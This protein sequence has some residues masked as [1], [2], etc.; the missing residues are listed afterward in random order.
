[1]TEIVMTST[2][3][4]ALRDDV[5]FLRNLVAGSDRWLVGF[6]EGYFAA[7]LIY[8]AQMLMH[9]GQLLGLAPGSGVWAL[10]IG[11]GPTLVFIPLVTWI[12]W[13]HR[14]QALPTPAGRAVT[15]VFAVAGLSNLALIAVIGSVAWREQSL[16]TWLIYPCAVFVFQGA[17]W[18]VAYCVRR[19]AWLAC[20][21]A[22]W[23][24][25]AIAMAFSVTEIA[26]YILVAAVG[27][28]AL[29]AAPGWAMMRAG[30]AAAPA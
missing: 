16:T 7:G 14:G 28:W 18:W 8:G 5:A 11:I 6:G 10:A 25:A 9:A 30:R 17:A 19:K 27:I 24:I 29:M 1:M 22:G 21:G 23:F 3:T 2:D 20:V 4:Q 15:A 12:T 26:H 13:R